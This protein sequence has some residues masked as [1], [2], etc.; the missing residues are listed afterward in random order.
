MAMTQVV[1]VTR[2]VEVTSVVTPRPVARLSPS[3]T[4]TQTMTA[5]PTLSA[6]QTT[7]TPILASATI[8]P[9]QPLGLSL[10]FFLAYYTGMTDLQKLEY[11]PTLPGKTVY[12]TAVVENVTTDGRV[13]LRLSEPLEGAITLQDVP[14]D[15]AVKISRGYWLDFTGT[16]AEFKDELNIQIVIVDVKVRAF[17]PAPTLT[18]TQARRR[19]W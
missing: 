12:W 19:G 14:H 16:M 11:V 15:I 2:V 13:I 17:Y 10:S 5:T 8:P 18:P 9:G 6:N 7:P 4:T 1:Q 3:P